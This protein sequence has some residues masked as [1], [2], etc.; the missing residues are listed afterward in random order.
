MN[1]LWRRECSGARVW[2]AA[3][4]RTAVAIADKLDGKEVQWKKQ[5]CRSKA[6][7]WHPQQDSFS[8]PV[9]QGFVFGNCVLTF[10]Q[11]QWLVVFKS[12]RVCLA[13]AEIV[14]KMLQDDLAAL[15]HS[16]IDVGD[17]VACCSSSGS[18][19]FFVRLL[20]FIRLVLM[21]KTETDSESPNVQHAKL[22]MVRWPKD[23]LGF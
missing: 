5:S 7:W 18:S 23:L 14:P 22:R 11:V 3:W 10:D 17:C 19:A 21:V 15:F 4:A 1:W 16:A 12:P 13:V 2:D 8:E 6:N 9:C 20:F